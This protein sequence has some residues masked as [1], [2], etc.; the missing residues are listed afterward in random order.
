METQ[1]QNWQAVSEIE[2]IYRT[3]VNASQCPQIR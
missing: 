1:N 3:K 2:L